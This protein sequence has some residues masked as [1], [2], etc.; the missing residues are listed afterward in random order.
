M[1]ERI[2][3][4]L[5][6]AEDQRSANLFRRYVQQMG[7]RLYP[8]EIRTQVCPRGSGEQFV[9]R[10]YPA[11]VQE[12]RRCVA[13][14]IRRAALIVHVDADTGTVEAEYQRLAEELMGA[15]H[16]AREAHERI[17]IVVPKRHT[18]TWLHG[19][20]DPAVTE[21]QNCKRELRE[22]DSKIAE[23]A[24]ALFRLTRQN[25]TAPPAN[26]PALAIAIPELRR[27]ES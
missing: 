12:Q 24:E 27:I 2:A 17:A 21:D 16:G 9:R 19:L 13:G 1:S 20:F 23:A 15:G 3:S 6:L 8:R 10:Q 22:H 26:L 11:E 14:R 18:E 4:L 5:I 25:A 7:R